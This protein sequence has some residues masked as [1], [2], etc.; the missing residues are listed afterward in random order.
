MP[1]LNFSDLQTSGAVANAHG[2]A[3]NTPPS[4]P[5]TP[6]GVDSV[7]PESSS[8]IYYNPRL[9]PKNYLSGP[10]SS[11]PATR[12]RQMLARPGIVVS[13][14]PLLADFS[15]TYCHYRLHPASAMVSVLGVPSKQDSIACIKG[16]LH[17]SLRF[18]L[19]DF[20]LSPKVAQRLLLRALDNP[21]WL[22]PL[23][24]IS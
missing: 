24:T 19:A 3:L 18:S 21:I 12:L 20:Y 15:E 1:S 4:V 14:L 9:D 23:S 17:A 10:L 8:G 22:S 16:M 13:T 6:T 5:G 11:N 2:Q 7:L